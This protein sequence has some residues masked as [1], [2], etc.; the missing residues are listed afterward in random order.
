MQ[1][2]QVAAGEVAPLHLLP[3]PPQPLARVEVRCV[4]PT[5]DFLLVALD[6]ASDRNL[7]SP[8]DLLENAR[9]MMFVVLDA[10]L[11]RDNLAD[12]IAGPDITAEAISFRAMPE[13]VS[14]QFPLPREQ[15]AR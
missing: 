6:G 5:V 14:D 1:L 10:K 12:P 13:K 9:D 15:F 7:R 2:F 3:V 8:T 11:L 4:A